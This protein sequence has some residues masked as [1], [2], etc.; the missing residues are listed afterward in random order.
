VETRGRSTAAQ[1]ERMAR[2]ELRNKQMPNKV[3]EERMPGRKKAPA[4]ANKRVSQTASHPSLAHMKR[5]R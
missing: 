4:A 2:I 1:G 3:R 5:L